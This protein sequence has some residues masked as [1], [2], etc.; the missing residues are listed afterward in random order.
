MAI[1]AFVL[2]A[3]LVFQLVSTGAFKLIA[4]TPSG[5]RIDLVMARQGI[6]DHLGVSPW[7]WNLAEAWELALAA[8]AV[9]GLRTP[10]FAVAA[11]LLA[12]ATMVG[13]LLLHV[14]VRDPLSAMLPAFLEL[15]VAVAVVAIHDP[16][17]E[18]I[19]GGSPG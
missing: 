10:A 9:V 2:T 14:R 6:R 11:G 1:A 16:T 12:A 17:L 5:Q 15:A 4:L 3:Y 19:Q 7:L 18:L 8:V 13:A